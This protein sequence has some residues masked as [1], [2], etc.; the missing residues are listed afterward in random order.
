MG[1]DTRSPLFPRRL[2]STLVSSKDFATPGGRGAMMVMID[3]EYDMT[4]I[5]FRNAIC[6]FILHD[7][8]FY[9]LQMRYTSQLVD[10]QHSPDRRVG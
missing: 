4:T 5:F 10:G 9:N 3:V 6:Y 7:S 8:V 1:T 2:Y